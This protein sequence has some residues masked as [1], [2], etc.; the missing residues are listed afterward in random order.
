MKT[1]AAIEYFGGKR[2]GRTKLAKAL[3]ISPSS[4]SQWAEDVPQLRAFQLERLTN[5]ELKA[6]D[7]LLD[8][9]IAKA[10]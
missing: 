9:P 1:K 6:D 2:G 8:A 7:D 3:G 5:G 10:A 4:V